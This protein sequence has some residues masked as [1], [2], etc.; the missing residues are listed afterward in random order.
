VPIYGFDDG[1]KQKVSLYR[2][3]TKSIRI[4]F[5][6]LKIIDIFILM[7]NKVFK[8]LMFKTIAMA[9]LFMLVSS[10]S[11]VVAHYICS[12]EKNVEHEEKCCCHNNEFSN[13]HQNT[14]ENTQLT[15]TDCGCCITQ[16]QPLNNSLPPVTISSNNLIQD[17]QYAVLSDINNQAFC[18]SNFNISI[19]G[20]P[21]ITQ[22]INIL[23]A[24]LRI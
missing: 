6:L 2:I 16:G 7:G 9:V 23:N 24:N 15:R 5:K 1:N 4:V 17:Y 19:S 8:K 22:D 13:S 11:I 3:E 18:S 21:L 10:N 14:H 12:Y 20:I